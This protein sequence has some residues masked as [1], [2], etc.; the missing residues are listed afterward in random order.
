MQRFISEHWDSRTGFVYLWPNGTA[1]NV[2]MELHI[3]AFTCLLVHQRL[4]L[5]SA[6]LFTFL[7]FSNPYLP[8]CEINFTQEKSSA[9]KNG[10]RLSCL[11]NIFYIFSCPKGN[12]VNCYMLLHSTVI[13]AVKPETSHWWY[14]NPV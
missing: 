7:T 8:K 1:I 12:I 13:L 6:S 5:L 11:K 2:S 3:P 4:C 14:E 10:Y 9:N